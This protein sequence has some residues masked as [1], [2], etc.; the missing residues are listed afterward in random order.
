VSAEFAQHRPRGAATML[1]A[2]A[3]FSLT[4]ARHPFRARR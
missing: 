1:H 2:A 4:R 3:R